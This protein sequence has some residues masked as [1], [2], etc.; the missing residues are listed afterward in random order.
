M[1]KIQT[2]LTSRF[3]GKLTK[4]EINYLTNFE[5]KT[6]NVFGLPKILK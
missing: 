2:N 6:S 1:I 3:E 4:N 5:V